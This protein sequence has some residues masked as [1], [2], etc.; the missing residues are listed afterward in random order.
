MTRMLDLKKRTVHNFYVFLENSCFAIF[1][2]EFHRH[3]TF[4]PKSENTG[5]DFRKH[6]RKYNP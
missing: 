3:S 4:S 1:T 5:G 6:I 2:Y